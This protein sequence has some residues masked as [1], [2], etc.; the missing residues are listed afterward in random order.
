MSVGLS[1]AQRPSGVVSPPLPPSPPPGLP[2]L[3]AVESAA[4]SAAAGSGTLNNPGVVSPPM[5]PPTLSPL[6]SPS[7][8]VGLTPH[9]QRVLSEKAIADAREKM[10][11]ADAKE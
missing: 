9:E 5:P 6:M 3:G 7:V 2:G 11:L 10:R 8:P 4:R 1:V